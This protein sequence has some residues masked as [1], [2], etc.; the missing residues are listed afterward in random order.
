MCLINHFH[1]ITYYIFYFS[2]ISPLLH[3]KLYVCVPVF[4]LICSEQNKQVR[5]RDL[6][7]EQ[8]DLYARSLPLVKSRNWTLDF[9]DSQLLCKVGFSLTVYFLSNKHKQERRSCVCAV[10][11][12]AGFKY[13]FKPRVFLCRETLPLIKQ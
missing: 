12:M 9:L 13:Q 11:K 3:T 4:A 1:R 2:H 10:L 8:T 6:N 7:I 5:F